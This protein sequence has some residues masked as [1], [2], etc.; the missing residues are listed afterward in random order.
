MLLNSWYSNETVT[1]AHKTQFIR[2]LP[3]RGQRVAVPSMC[4]AFFTRG[5]RGWR[6]RRLNMLHAG[7]IGFFS[8]CEFFRLVSLGGQ[9]RR[10]LFRRW[11]KPRARLTV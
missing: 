1:H 5:S 4:R 6:F 7:W 8:L 10:V 11:Q 2:D 3:P 9:Q